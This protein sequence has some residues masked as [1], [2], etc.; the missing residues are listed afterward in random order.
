MAAHYTYLD[1]LIAPGSE[2]NTSLQKFV[3]AVALGVVMLLVAKV[4]TSRLQTSEGVRD[5]VVPSE[6]INFFGFI[7]VLI[8]VFLKY[9]DSVLGKE[10]RKH[11]SFTAS[12]FFFIFFANLVGLVPGMPA[13]TTT[14]WINVAMAIVVF[15]YFNFHGVKENGLGYFKHFLGPAWWLIP[16]YFPLEI[17][18]M[19]IRV[20]TL[21][22]RLYWN[23]NADHIVLGTFTDILPPVM[24][25][26]FYFVGTFV[27]FMQ[28]FVF[29]TLTMIYILLAVEHQEDH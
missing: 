5:N 29:T 25:V 9:H 21:N 18:S 6:K 19:A 15:F 26:P 27:S 23:I 20:L 13:I 2:P 7:D 22:L 1:S 11:A 8:E 3:V 10:N 17:L 16:L 28:A 4:L 24:G 14:V 12:L